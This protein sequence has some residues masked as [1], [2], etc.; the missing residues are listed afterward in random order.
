MGLRPVFLD[1]NVS[2]STAADSLQRL[3]DA[4]LI[5]RRRKADHEVNRILARQFLEDGV[6][7]L[8]PARVGPRLQIGVPTAHSASPIADKL[9]GGDMWVMPYEGGSVAGH[10]V[11]PLHEHAPR[12][13]AEDPEMH[14]LLAIVDSL[15]VGSA[16]ER[17]V[18]AEELRACL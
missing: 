17:E 6:R 9:M 8:A 5:R 16:R 2:K 12:I 4:G 11:P 18:A 1:G 14:R 3:A 10:A 15:R 13:A 7:W